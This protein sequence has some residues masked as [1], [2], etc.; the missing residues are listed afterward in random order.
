MK[1]IHQEIELRLKQT[2]AQGL[3]RSLKPPQGIDF[4]S[5]DYLGLSTDPYFRTALLKKLNSENRFHLSSPSSRLLRGSPYWHQNVEKQL[6]SFKGTESS[7]LFP[8][9][10]QANLG[11]LTT[12]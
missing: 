12:L 11:L 6:A 4:C 8:T 10:Y 3:Y 9:G 1:S 7:L 5:N 2:S